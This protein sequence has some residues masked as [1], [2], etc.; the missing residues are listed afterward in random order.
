VA[1]GSPLPCADYAALPDL[2]QVDE[3]KLS[4]RSIS[5][6]RITSHHTSPPT[7]SEPPP[8]AASTGGI[9]PAYL[10][11]PTVPPP[12][13]KLDHTAHFCCSRPSPLVCPNQPLC[14][15][16]DVLRRGRALE[17]NERSALSYGRAIAVSVI[18]SSF[19]PLRSQL[20]SLAG[21]QRCSRMHLMLS[22]RSANCGHYHQRSREKL[23][24]RS[25]EKYR[26]YHIL[27]RRFPRW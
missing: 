25:V 23:R 21:Y 7:R 11:H 2:R 16:L 27:A 5:E 20:V 13:V 17:N 15:A 19:H 18:L 10:L 4:P 12:E 1:R 9:P 26:N 14:A 3:E 6:S 24:P 22:A 8:R